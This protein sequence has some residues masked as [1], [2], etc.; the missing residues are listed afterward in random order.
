M[1]LE[2][3]SLLDRH[4]NTLKMSDYLL[5]KLSLVSRKRLASTLLAFNKCV[6]NGWLVPNKPFTKGLLITYSSPKY[7]EYH[8]TS[9][10]IRDNLENESAPIGVPPNLPL[11]NLPK[12]KE[13]T[14]KKESKRKSSPSERPSFAEFVDSLTK[15]SAYQAMNLE[16]ELAKMDAWLALPKN[17]HRK[18]TRQF[19][20][21]WL[22]KI[23]EPLNGHQFSPH[24]KPGRCSEYIGLERCANTAVESGLCQSCFTRILPK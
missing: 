7:A 24:P 11:P 16:R 8:R 13:K 22:N 23:D 14:L 19:V 9:S 15:N 4:E 6:A 18:K 20:L 17:K 1:W 5:E 21:N 3:L 10:A 12:Q 2:V